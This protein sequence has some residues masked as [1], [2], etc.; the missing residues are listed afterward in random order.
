[1]KPPRGTYEFNASIPRLPNCCLQQ[2]CSHQCGPP[3]NPWTHF[4]DQQIEAPERRTRT[5]AADGIVFSTDDSP[6]PHSPNLLW[7]KEAA[8]V[9][10]QSTVESPRES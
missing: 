9:R 7:V 4:K 8:S 5:Q 2:S 1:M 6:R 3:S 10:F